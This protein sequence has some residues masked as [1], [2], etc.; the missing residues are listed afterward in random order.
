MINPFSFI[1]S[2]S[3]VNWLPLV[4]C[5]RWFIHYRRYDVWTL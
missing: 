2:N 3:L 5:F 1:F 4:C